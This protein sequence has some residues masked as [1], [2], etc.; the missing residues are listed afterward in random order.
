MTGEP[1]PHGGTP[2]LPK[3]YLRF[4]ELFNAGRYWES[5]EVL[6]GPW[7]A[8]RS[9]FYKGMI[10][11]ASAF[12]HGRRGNPRG[13]RKQLLKA[14]KYL[15][16]YLPH[17]LGVHVEGRLFHARRCLALVESASPPSG[18][19]LT[20]ALPFDRLALRREWI[21]GDEP[22]LFGSQH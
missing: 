1:Y 12:V 7:R 22:E 4:V 15:T 3:E 5:H 9:P 13:V 20:R 6:E 18:D 17:Y 10:I 8:H 21:R 11:Y 14:E 2:P 19:R 16:G